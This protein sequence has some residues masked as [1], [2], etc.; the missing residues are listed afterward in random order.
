MVGEDVRQWLKARPFR[1][2]EIIATAGEHHVVEHAEVAILSPNALLV[3]DPAT[4][5]FFGSGAHAHHRDPHHRDR[6]GG[7]DIAAATL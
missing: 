6:K 3:L 4:G 1:E 7:S 2:F 5:S